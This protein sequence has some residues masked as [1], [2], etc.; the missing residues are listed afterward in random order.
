MMVS[1]SG[2]NAHSQFEMAQTKW[3]RTFSSDQ[4]M[5]VAGSFFQFSAG[6][7]W[8]GLKGFDISPE[9]AKSVTGG[10]SLLDNFKRNRPENMFVVQAT[11]VAIDKAIDDSDPEKSFASRMWLIPTLES[12]DKELVAARMSRVY[13]TS[14]AE[15][16]HA[17]STHIDLLPKIYESL[18]KMDQFAFPFGLQAQLAVNIISDPDYNGN[19]EQI[20]ALRMGKYRMILFAPL[21]EN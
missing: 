11:K 14:S 8:S 16:R 7:G 21:K 9:G 1:F 19:D 18:I 15:R 2:P 13:V 4:H 5:W 12:R 10:D 20:A 6:G 3:W 17:I